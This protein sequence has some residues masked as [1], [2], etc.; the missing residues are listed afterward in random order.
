[1]SST[2]THGIVRLGDGRTWSI[3]ESGQKIKQV[4]VT[5]ADATAPY[6]TLVFTLQNGNSFTVYSNMVTLEA[7]S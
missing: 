4:E 5:F 6:F 7:C 1:M 2:Y 3:G